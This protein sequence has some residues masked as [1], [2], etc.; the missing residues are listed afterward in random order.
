[1]ILKR[2]LGLFFAVVVGSGGCYRPHLMM[3]NEY[4]NVWSSPYFIWIDKKRNITYHT[5]WGSRDYISEVKEKIPE[6]MDFVEKYEGIRRNGTPL[7]I[8]MLSGR[9]YCVL[10]RGSHLRE[11]SSGFYD[12]EERCIALKDYEKDDFSRLEQ[13]TFFHEYLHFLD[14]LDG[15]MDWDEEEVERKAAELLT[16]F[17]I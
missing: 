11:K 14:F 12:V 17:E 2:L 9:D 16:Q 10:E 13:R 15:K 8:I 6:L 7:K 1:M 5:L 4:A 3:P